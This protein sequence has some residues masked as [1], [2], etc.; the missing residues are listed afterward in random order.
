MRI[1]Q[2]CASCKSE[3]SVSDS[4]YR[5]LIQVRCP[6]C[7]HPN[8][9]QP[10]RKPRSLT[11]H[12]AHHV[13]THSSR[14]APSVGGGTSLRRGGSAPEMLHGP[15]PLEKL[16][17][18][19]ADS[20]RCFVLGTGPS[21]N[22]Y[23]LEDITGGRWPSIG[24]NDAYRK[25]PYLDALVFGDYDWIRDNMARVQRWQHDYPGRHLFWMA[26]TKKK[27]TR[28]RWVRN[29]RNHG[30]CIDYETN[31]LVCDISQP[32]EKS[33][34][35]YYEKAPQRV[36]HDFSLPL[37]LNFQDSIIFS[38]INLAY[39]LGAKEIYLLGVEAER[40]N[41][42][43]DPGNEHR[44]P[45][46]RQII[47]KLKE[48]SDE[49]A[50]HGTRLY[51]CRNTGELAKV[52]STATYEDVVGNF[53]VPHLER[54]SE[55]IKRAGRCFVL[56]AGDSLNTVPLQTLCGWPVLG[57]NT[58][59]LR[60]PL[61][62]G[63]I[64]GDP[65]FIGQY[66]QTIAEWQRSREEKPIIFWHGESERKDLV[67]VV[68]WEH[69]ANGQVLAD[70]PLLCHYPKLAIKRSIITPAINLAYWL[71]AKQIYLLGVDLSN[72]K[73]FWDPSETVAKYLSQPTGAFPGA[74]DIV[75]FI[76]R[77]KD[78]LKERGVFLGKSTPG[79]LLD[80]VMDYIPLGE[81]ANPRLLNKRFE[82]V[83]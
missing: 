34:V 27:K 62:D 72:N 47:T 32:L 1:E 3:Y 23:N 33:S 71:G 20:G 18:K 35:Y 55:R 65:G 17:R 39:L 46:S 43:W 68:A 29:N 79:G 4:Q 8:V 37:T 64:F 61:M 42:F 63:L 69:A 49:Y 41:H 9:K 77:M 56:G 38:A 15:Q 45:K 2:C 51:T 59:W 44:F 36:I 83:M 58:A 14:I 13:I 26:E 57:V 73:H 70:N 82:G 81:A 10:R 76:G 12:S 25:F 48:Q 40:N 7:G 31:D 54:L 80:E 30:H 78:K 50:A 16:R 67:R 60:Y 19:I 52:L 24:V 75:E 11:V 28:L 74:R 53:T 66:R 22:H 6:V 5:E 21:L